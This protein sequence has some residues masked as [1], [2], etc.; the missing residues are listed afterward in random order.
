MWTCKHSNR[1]LFLFRARGLDTAAKIWLEGKHYTNE[2]QANIS[3]FHFQNF[4]WFFRLCWMT[5]GWFYISS[6]WSLDWVWT[7]RSNLRSLRNFYKLNSAWFLAS[8]YT[9]KIFSLLRIGCLLLNC[10][11]NISIFECFPIFRSILSRARC[12]S[13]LYFAFLSAEATLT[14]LTKAI[15]VAAQFAGKIQ[16][17][18]I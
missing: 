5:R 18:A 6:F 2:K 17:G 10:H 4:P 8:R 12:A 9:K 1:L 3:N 16:L 7:F 14:C 13:N 15:F 11:L